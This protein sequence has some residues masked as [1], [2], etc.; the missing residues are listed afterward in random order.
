MGKLFRWYTWERIK[1]AAWLMQRTRHECNRCCL[2][3]E[4]FD[5]CCY[6]VWREEQSREN[7]Q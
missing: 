3:C 2:W 1:W 5:Q 4:Y 6:D 7:G